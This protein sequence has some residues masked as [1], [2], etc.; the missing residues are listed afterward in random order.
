MAVFAIGCAL[1]AGPVSCAWADGDPASDV[2]VDSPAFL[3]TDSG[4]SAQQQAQLHSQLRAAVRRG[5]PVRVAVIASRSDLG[6]IGALWHQP[7]AYSQF[8]GRELSLVYH[9]ELLVV[10]PDGFGVS[11]DGRGIPSPLQGLAPRRGELATATAQAITR[12]TGT[13]AATVTAAA[14]VAT[15]SPTSGLGWWLATAIGVPLIAAA[16]L[17]SLRVAPLRRRHR[18]S[19]ARH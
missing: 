5:R 13:P 7:Q 4:A 8:L 9:G 6:S 2:L 1:A 10:M 17:V 14:V 16:W 19:R 3:A 11:R 18:V 15:S 12:L